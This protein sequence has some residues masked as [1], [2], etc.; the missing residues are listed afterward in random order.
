MRDIGYLSLSEIQREHGRGTLFDSMFVFENAPIEDAI[1]TVT[2]PD[3]ARFSPIE[4]ESLTHYPLTVVSHMTAMRCS[5][6]SR[7]FAK[8]CRIFGPQRSA[9]DCCTCCVN[10]P[11]SATTPLT[12]WTFSRRPSVL[13]SSGLATRPPPDPQS[14]TV[15]EM[16]ERQVHATP[17]AVA[18]TAGEW[19]ALHLCRTPRRRRPVGA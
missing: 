19:R 17:D 2:T 3:G 4:M 11:T 1:R 18:L 7:R 14:A 15:W 6:L 5:C 10:S 9:S 12:R 16:F 13:N 8:R